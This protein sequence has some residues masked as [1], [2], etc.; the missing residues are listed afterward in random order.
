MTPNQ[1]QA[2]AFG[3]IALL[4]GISIIYIQ[5]NERKEPEPDGTVTVR[6]CTSGIITNETSIPIRDGY[7]T[8]LNHYFEIDNETIIQVDWWQHTLWHKDDFY[9]YF[10][11]MERDICWNTEYLGEG[12]SE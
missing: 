11:D 7:S 9:R 1:K 2:I 8:Y 12:A 5:I 6:F 10:T 4:I 3:I